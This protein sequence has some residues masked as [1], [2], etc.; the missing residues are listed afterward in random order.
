MHYFTKSAFFL[1]IFIFSAVCLADSADPFSEI[2][3][4][5][6]EERA[7]VKAKAEEAEKLKDKREAEE[8]KK[9]IAAEKEKQRAA[10]K[11]R[12]EGQIDKINLGDDQS[13]RFTIDR[14]TISGNSLISTEELLEN[15]PLVFN[16]SDKP[17]DKAESSS[18]YDFRVLYEIISE[19]GRPR[20]LSARTIQGFT[21]YI[22]SVYQEK[23]Y[24]GIFVYVPSEAVGGLEQLK[25]SLPIEVLEAVVSRVNVKY[26]DVENNVRE[27]GFLKE[28]VVREWS[29]IKEGQVAN[30]KR[31]D[32]L[33]NLLNLNLDRYVAAKVSKGVDPKSLT[34]GYDI[35]EVKPWHYY[36]Q[37]DNSGTDDRQWSPRV[38]YVNTNLTGIDDRLSLMGQAPIDENQKENHSI[39]GSYDVPLGSP[40]LRISV[41]GGRSEFDTDGGSGIKFLGD[42]KFF[43]SV[44]RYN[45]FQEDGWH[46]DVLGS[47]S[48]EESQITPSLF[49]SLLGTDV[50]MDI[51]TVGV[52][53]HRSDDMSRTS[54]IF[55]RSERMSS[56][57]QAE[58]DKA[59]PPSGSIS[60]DFRIYTYTLSHSQYLD[61]DK[62]QR[63]SGTFRAITSNT[64]LVPAK[65]TTFGGMYTVR[66]YNEDAIV[67]DGGILASA[68]YEFDLVKQ[69][70]AAEGESKSKP[71][72]RKLAPLAFVD[73]GRAKIRKA[74]GT[75]KSINELCSIGLGAIIELGDHFNGAVYYGHPLR[76][77][78]TTRRNDGRLN[79][80]LLLRW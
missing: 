69:A 24:A 17:L 15:V 44:L 43:G 39:F 42:G 10:A 19:P 36:V 30:N 63:F 8:E 40:R 2:I 14:I 13:Q 21:R 35:Y 78:G 29:P 56:S 74:T 7:E 60:N 23:N 38:G 79:V 12:F 6:S 4:V 77:A 70:E 64:R 34:V 16:V 32:D 62:V 65:M 41:Y 68:Q 33:V 59:R 58:F 53:I 57:D 25:G 26:F 22:L 67:A 66:G 1:F 72:L 51:W 11:T 61:P 28:S 20:Q 46:F 80:S 55:N 9:R 76:G 47:L 71:L 50:D 31:L 5:K 54:F 48:H 49:P 37:I 52:D 75:E 27:K 45:V 18:L 3:P 73:Y